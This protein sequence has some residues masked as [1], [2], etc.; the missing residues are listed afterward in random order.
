MLEP[1]I[2][3]VINTLLAY[4]FEKREGIRLLRSPCCFCVRLSEIYETW[5]V[6]HGTC[7]R[8]NGVLYNFFPS[9][10]V[11][12][13]TSYRLLGNGSVKTLARQGIRP[14]I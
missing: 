1:R 12:M 13:C 3:D 14:R 6:Y 4:S 10:C 8:L 2:K 11:L 5:C 7:A 9:V